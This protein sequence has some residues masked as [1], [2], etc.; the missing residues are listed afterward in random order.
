MGSSIKINLMSNSL[1]S[2]E[3]FID[4][5]NDRSGALMLG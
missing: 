4:R 3:N 2:L 1:L 5:A